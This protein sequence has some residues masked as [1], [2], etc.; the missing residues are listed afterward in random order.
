[1]SATDSKTVEQGTIESRNKELFRS[2]VDAM[3]AGDWEKVTEVWSPE[4]VHY[5]RCGTYGRDEVAQLMGMF[6]FS[7]PDLNF[8]IE[9]VLADGDRLSARMTATCTHKGDFAGIPATGRKVQVAVMGQVRIV[10]GKIVE[11]WNVMDELHFLN[12]LGLV[13]DDQLN[14]ILA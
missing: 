2:F 12:Q 7:F 1:M 8:H 3:N 6:R 10:D 11:H 14:L 4:M 13:S 9:D 5:G